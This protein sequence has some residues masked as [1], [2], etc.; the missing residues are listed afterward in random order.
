MILISLFLI[1]YLT[2]KNQCIKINSEIAEIEN[3]IIKNTNIVK[4]LQRE[5]EYYLSEKYISKS[6][7]DIMLVAIPEPEIINIENE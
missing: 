2:I 6:M 7:E 3:S 1:C 4:D 5:Q